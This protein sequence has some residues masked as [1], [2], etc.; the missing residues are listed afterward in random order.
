MAPS[1]VGANKTP[2]AAKRPAGSQF[3]TQ[4]TRKRAKGALLPASSR[5]QCARV[6]ALFQFD[7][8]PSA[9]AST[10]PVTATDAVAP[11]GDVEPLVPRVLENGVGEVREVM[12][13]PVLPA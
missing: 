7:D 8:P 5:R 11:E 10:A 6:A 4:S 3:M 1:V 2:A 9:G 12:C 13:L